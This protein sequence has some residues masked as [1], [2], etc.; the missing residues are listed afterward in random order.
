L[1]QAVPYSRIPKKIPYAIADYT[2][3]VD[4]GYYFVDKTRF[5]HELEK[6]KIP[7][8]SHRPAESGKPLR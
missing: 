8:A 6:Y 4:E 1:R 7:V 5:I 3:I 2:Q